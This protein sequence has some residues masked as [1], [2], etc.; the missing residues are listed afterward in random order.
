[1]ARDGISEDY[2]RARVRAQHDAAYFRARCDGEFVN[3]Y[4]TAEAAETAARDFVQ[5]LLRSG[6]EES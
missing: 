2:A 6:K 1:M 3:D 4:P 5:N